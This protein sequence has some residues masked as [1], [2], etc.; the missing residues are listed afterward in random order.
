[1][2]MSVVITFVDIT[3]LKRAEEATARLAAIVTSSSDAIISKSLDGTV[4]SWNEGAG[5]LFGYSAEEMI[6]RPIRRLIP[7]D[8]RG[9]EDGILGRI[10]AGGPVENY[11]TLRRHKKRALESAGPAPHPA[12]QMR[13]RS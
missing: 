6:G 11:E 1:M 12:I 5:H 13:R 8:R 4:L 2:E 10:A 9:E 7:A 3:A